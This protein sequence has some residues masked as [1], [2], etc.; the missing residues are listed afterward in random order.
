[1][2][3]GLLLSVRVRG[4]GRHIVWEMT[5]S[6]CPSQYDALQ[7]L[8]TANYLHVINA[9]LVPVL[10]RMPTSLVAT[11]SGQVRLGAQSP[12]SNSHS[13]ARPQLRTSVCV[14][15]T[16]SPNF[17][18]RIDRPLDHGWERASIGREHLRLIT[19]MGFPTSSRMVDVT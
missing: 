9:S 12:L 18:L 14:F 16:A 3:S 2:V 10:V 5:A 15:S 6:L 7:G 17:L 1:M 8:K 13:C 4:K 19:G 11:A